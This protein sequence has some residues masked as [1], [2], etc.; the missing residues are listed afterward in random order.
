[1]ARAVSGSQGLGVLPQ[2]LI[3]GMEKGRPCFSKGLLFPVVG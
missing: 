3:C 1:M 2:F